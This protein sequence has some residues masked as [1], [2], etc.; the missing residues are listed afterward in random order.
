MRKRTISSI[1]G[2]FLISLLLSSCAQNP[3]QAKV[4]VLNPIGSPPP[5]PL[6]GMAPRLD[7][8]DGKTVYIVDVR[9]PLTH[10][11]FEEMQKVLAEKYPKTNWIL[12]EKA[13]SYSNDDPELWKE[14]KAKSDAMIIGIGH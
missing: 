12:K 13:G 7:T 2:I 14:I 4:V 11:L 6:I 9:Y 8:L 5:K 1:I 10:Q 3:E